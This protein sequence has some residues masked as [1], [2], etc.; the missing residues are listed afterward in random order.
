MTEERKAARQPAS[1]RARSESAPPEPTPG[2]VYRRLDRGR[3]LQSR[4]A[5]MKLIRVSRSVEEHQ[6]K[7]VNTL[8]DVEWCWW[9]SKIIMLLRF[10]ADKV[11]MACDC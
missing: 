8:F 2:D 4:V 10:P 6:E 3:S 11:V 5:D 9:T 7:R 1:R